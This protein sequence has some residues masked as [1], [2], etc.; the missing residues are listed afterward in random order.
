MAIHEHR[1]SDTARRKETGMVKGIPKKA[2]HAPLF[3]NEPIEYNKSFSRGIRVE[4]DDF[5]FIFISGTASVDEKG[6][7]YCPGDFLAQTKR[8]FDNITALLRSEGARWHDVV[9][10]RCY[11]KD[12]RFYDKFN[13]VRNQFYRKQRLNPFP[14]SVCI[15]AGLC[16]PEL[17]VEI[18]A[19]AI[20]RAQKKTSTA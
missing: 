9:Q 3:L 5:T 10:T 2:I 19:I 1:A 13:K 4:L 17:L 12:M 7:T 20:L 15:Q 6:K 18:E 16:R 8:T 11:L 14:A